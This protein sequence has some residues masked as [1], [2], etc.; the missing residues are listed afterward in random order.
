M[1]PLPRNVLLEVGGD[2]L[3][4]YGTLLRRSTPPGRGGEIPY[5]FTRAGNGLYLTN[6]VSAGGLVVKTA[7]NGFARVEQL[8][9]PVNGVLQNYLKLEQTATNS[10]LQSQ[11]WG[12]APWAANNMTS[13]TN[14]AAAAPDGTTTATSLIPNGTSTPFHFMNQPIT[15]TSGEFCAASFFVKANGYNG[16]VIRFG[17][18]N[19]TN[20]FQATFDLSTGLFGTQHVAAGAGVLT[21]FTSLALANGWYWLLIWGA[22]NAS[23]TAAGIS[24]YV[25]DTLAHADA[26]T[27]WS[28]DTTHGAFVWG[29]QVERNGSNQLPPS[30]YI[31]TTTVTV[32][33]SGDSAFT[34][35]YFAGLGA[36]AFWYYVRYLTRGDFATLAAAQFPSVCQ[37]GSFGAPPNWRTIIYST[38][39]GAYFGASGNSAAQSASTLTVA[40]TFNQVVEHLL[41]VT[42]PGVAVLRTAVQQGA[43]VVGSTPGAVALPADYSTHTLQLSESGTYPSDDY[44]IS[45]A[46]VGAGAVSQIADVRGVL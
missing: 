37:L 26:G 3:A 13:V 45:R 2:V 40:P 15:I 1:T 29:A 28:G 6:D 33:R 21:G 34:V 22:V 12:T 32:A 31:A 30:S 11:T 4:K 19:S 38:G 10:C 14:A 17:D 39:A 43:D 20:A 35:P 25:Y 42:A 41:T 16:I 9:D 24:C 36:N 18:A 8:V 7:G 27:S 23:V 46:V 44:L 5:T